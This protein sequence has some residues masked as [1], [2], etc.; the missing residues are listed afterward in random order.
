MRKLGERLAVR[1]DPDETTFDASGQE[2]SP[3]YRWQPAPG[4]RPVIVIVSYLLAS[5]T[6]GRATMLVESTRL[7]AGEAWPRSRDG[8]C[9]QTH[10]QTDANRNFPVV[11]WKS[12]IEAG[13]MLVF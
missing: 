6:S 8:L 3:P 5:P 4:W 10:L 11:Q 9:T 7:P 1:Y 13:L 2:T 12:C